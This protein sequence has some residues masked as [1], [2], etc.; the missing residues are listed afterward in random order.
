MESTE[1]DN[2][3]M[4]VSA[5]IR[6][7]AKKAA[8]GTSYRRRVG[9]LPSGQS[10]AHLHRLTSG[11]CGSS[12][13]YLGGYT[14][15]SKSLAGW[16]FGYT[17]FNAT[18][19][20]FLGHQFGD[21]AHAQRSKTVGARSDPP[22]QMRL[23]LNLVHGCAVNK[24]ERASGLIRFT[25][26]EPCCVAL[27]GGGGLPKE[28]TRYEGRLHWKDKTPVARSSLHRHAQGQEPHPKRLSM[29][30]MQAV[31]PWQQPTSIPHS[32]APRSDI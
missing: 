9:C 27:T 21:H 32:A 30:E 16:Q 23:M 17:H 5:L 10:Q 12:S 28:G 18:A 24:I 25:P 26:Q 3:V 11:F 8:L 20:F 14:R 13:L 31:A 15:P 1:S 7:Q 22:S 29:P 6:G 19:Q 2:P 4:R